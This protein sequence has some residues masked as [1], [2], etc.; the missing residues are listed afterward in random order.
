MA[1]ELA[2]RPAQTSH[3]V[4][5]WPSI[6]GVVALDRV[7]ECAP[8]K[9]GSMGGVSPDDLRFR[10]FYVCPTVP[11]RKMIDE[12]AHV[13]HSLN[14]S[15]ARDQHEL[16]TACRAKSSR[17]EDRPDPG[18][19]DEREPAQ[20]KREGLG[21]VRSDLEQVLIE[22]PKRGYVQ[23]PAEGQRAV[24]S[25]HAISS[26]RRFARRLG[27]AR[28]WPFVSPRSLDGTCIANLLTQT[29]CVRRSCP[30]PPGCRASPQALVPPPHPPRA[31]RL[32]CHSTAIGRACQRAGRFCRILRQWDALAMRS[33]PACR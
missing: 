24:P 20:V 29:G 27:R 19:V 22:E 21:S 12:A 10:R 15:R 2:A 8:G 7:M 16:A 4:A 5:A 23:F 33:R 9:A 1:R 30:A 18:R 31:R 26:T 11:E 32:E 13:E 28:S 14:L 6:H 3:V 17:D 25:S